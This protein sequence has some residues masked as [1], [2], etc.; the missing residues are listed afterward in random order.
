M[1]KK[2]MRSKRASIRK[3][4]KERMQAELDKRKEEIKHRLKSEDLS[5]E[6]KREKYRRE[7]HQEKIRLMGLARQEFSARKRMLGDITDEG[8]YAGDGEEFY[9]GFV[10]P[11]APD[12]MAEALVDDEDHEE[13]DG[14]VGADEAFV[15]EDT[16]EEREALRQF[17]APIEER[18][19]IPGGR[20]EFQEKAGVGPGFEE[21]EE[22]EV[23][24]LFY[25]A[26]NIIFHPITT[27][28]EF[29]DYLITPPG[30]RNVAIFYLLSILPA[31]LFAYIMQ[32]F[33]A[34]IAEQMA[35]PIAQSTMSQQP[36]VLVLYATNVFGLFIFSLCVSTLNLFF[37]GEAN[38]VTL[39]SY[40]AFVEAVAG[41]VLYTLAVA[42]AAATMVFPPLLLMIILIGP[43][44]II[45]KIVLNVIVLMSAYGYGVFASLLLIIGAVL[46]QLIA[47]VFFTGLIVSLT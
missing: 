4:I 26:S 15:L 31:V 1:D 7:A 11:P 30:L 47:G 14:G 10:E 5:I 36:N 9:E 32:S 34:Q 39:V 21:E 25:Y 13:P 2:D 28:D 17:E 46:V 37:A 20:E 24:N 8:E 27:L 41:V 16:T 22:F 19:V 3:E 35:T 33:G 12:A 38:F 23:N 18:D 45:W 42:I 44:F 29:D 6:E 43:A 40:F